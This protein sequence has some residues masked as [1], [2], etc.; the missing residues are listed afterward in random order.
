MPVN[1][2]YGVGRTIFRTRFPMKRNIW[3]GVTAALLALSLGS[4][5]MFPNFLAVKYFSGEEVFVYEET[6]GSGS[7][8]PLADQTIVPR[9]K[10][11]KV[12]AET[13]EYRIF[14]VA[15]VLPVSVDGVTVQANDVVISGTTAYVAYNTAG[16]EYA[17][18][19]QIIDFSNENRPAITAEIGLPNADVNAVAVS[20]SDIYIAGAWE[21]EVVGATDRAFV[22]RIGA[23]EL[24]GLNGVNAADIAARRVPLSSFAATGIAIKGDTVFVSTGAENGELEILDATLTPAEPPIVYPDIRDIAAYHGGVIALQGTDTS[25]LATGRV[26]VFKGDGTEFDALPIPDFGSPEAKATIE[27]YDNH[28]AFLGLSEGGFTAVWLKDEPEQGVDT[29]TTLFEIE[30]P[31]VAWSTKT[32]TNS[33]SY[34]GDLVFT[35]NGEAGFRVF[36]V[37]EDLKRDQQPA[38][39]GELIGFVPFDEFGTDDEGNYWSA[40]HIEYRDE[41]LI[42][43]SGTGGVNFYTLTRIN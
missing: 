30:N 23:S 24:G 21:P 31:E 3:I 27:V 4:C 1:G 37:L 39:F 2:G 22:A 7:Y 28:Y 10:G 40:N 29:V 9:G 35:A 38:E 43:A 36:R 32:T 6:A 25:G 11:G 42:V 20:G 19:L 14:H 8:A 16:E 18:A 15:Q 17:G 5:G 33:A 26:L 41:V 13:F 34:S 12:G